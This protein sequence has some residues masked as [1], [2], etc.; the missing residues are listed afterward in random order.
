MAVTFLI[1][2]SF[3]MVLRGLQNPEVVGDLLTSGLLV[4]L[5]LCK[6]QVALH[7]ATVLV[8]PGTVL[9][10]RQVCES[11]SYRMLGPAHSRTLPVPQVLP[12]QVPVSVLFSPCHSNLSSFLFRL[13]NPTPL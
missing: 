3:P 9:L 1:I 8:L 7:M 11:S 6:Q 5:A 12:P 4:V 13:P 2:L 10:S